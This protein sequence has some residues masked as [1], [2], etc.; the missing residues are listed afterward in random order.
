MP[1]SRRQDAGDAIQIIVQTQLSAEDIRIATKELAPYAVAQNDCLRETGNAVLI[2][3]YTAQL[4]FHAEHGKVV[5]TYTDCL[6]ALGPLGARQ[7]RADRARGRD[8]GYNAGVVAQFLHL[9]HR[10]SNVALLNP[11]EIVLDGHQFLRL[12]VRKRPQQN[13][14]DQAENCCIPADSECHHQHP[15][16]GETGIRAEAPE[17]IAEIHNSCSLPKTY[18]RSIGTISDNRTH[19]P[20]LWLRRRNPYLRQY[21]I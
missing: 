6:D 10:H 2:A 3:E 7:V 13:R 14:V 19:A 1:E 8:F 4:S 11:A 9:G 17:N 15:Y 18:R 16:C 5:R 20:A 12:R 21:L